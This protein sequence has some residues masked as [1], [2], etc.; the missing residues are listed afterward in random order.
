MAKKRNR[1]RSGLS[2]RGGTSS[3]TATKA[4]AG[5]PPP[6]VAPATP[7]GPNRQARKEEARRQRE[8]VRRRR[9]RRRVL[10]WVGIVTAV[11]VVAAGIA[12]YFVLRPNAAAA[13]DCGSVQTVQPYPGG[14]D[15]T[16]IQSAGTIK[17]PPALSTYRS[18][19]PASGPHNP[20]PEP[21]GVY[22]N[23]P[24]IYQ[25]IHSLEHGAVVIWYRPGAVSSQLDAIRSFYS[26][27]SE[28]DHVIVAPYSYPGQGK[29]SALPAGESMVMVAWHHVQDCGKLSLGAAK[30]FVGAYRTPTGQ[31]TPLGYKGD[32]PEAGRPIS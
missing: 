26:Q 24:N 30:G 32:A 27:T 28:Q 13:A 31:S 23:P 9:V 3:G 4:R 21:A 20:T 1:A 29:A 6:T 22:D 12:T 19:P 8:A 7:G 11:L 5:Q 2:A 15:R 25:V 18:T 16:H 14:N 17:T 10:R